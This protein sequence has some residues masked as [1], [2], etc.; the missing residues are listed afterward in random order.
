MNTDLQKEIIRVR[1][2]YSA[3]ELRDI[4]ARHVYDEHFEY[5]GRMV[6]VDEWREPS[7]YVRKG[8]EVLVRGN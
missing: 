5:V 8:L 1:E 7:V 2:L 4:Y 6:V 3:D